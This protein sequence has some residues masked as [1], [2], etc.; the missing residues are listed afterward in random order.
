MGKQNAKLSSPSSPPFS[1]TT[2]YFGDVQI[3]GNKPTWMLRSA[4]KRRMRLQ[5]KSLN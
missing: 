2:L 5:I 4:D 3:C 1:W